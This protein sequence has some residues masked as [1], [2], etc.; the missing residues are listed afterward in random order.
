MPFPHVEHPKWLQTVP[1]RAIGHRHTARSI[2]AS[3]RRIR[4]GA[5]TLPTDGRGTAVVNGGGFAGMLAALALHA[6]ADRV[7]V[8]ER[9]RFPDTPG[10][11]PGQPQGHHAHLLLEAGHR[12]LEEQL[13]PGIRAQLLAAGASRV[14][15]SRELRWRSSAGWMAEHDSHLEILSCSRGLLD[16][17]LR[18]RV[19]AECPG[20]EVHEGTDVVGLLGSPE[21]VTGVRIRARGDHN[22]VH[23]VPAEM[24]VD[25]SGR[26]SSLPKWLTTL[27]CAPVRDERVDAG[28][29]YLSRQYHRPAGA[30]DLGFSALYLQT[31]PP[32]HPW[33][34]ALLPIEGN[35][36]IVS[37]GAM[38]GWEPAP[39][40]PG[41]NA[42]LAQLD[43]L[44]SE[45]LRDAEPASTVR[46]FHPGPSV[47]RHYEDKTTPDG[48]VALGDANSC[49][50]PVYGQGLSATAL[51][52]RELRDAVQHHGSLDHRATRAA[53][54]RIA[55]VT[56]P[57]WL[58]SASEDVRW[59]RTIGGPSGALTRIQHRFLDRV[60]ER[61]TTDPR[62]TAAFHEVM[63]LVSAP[64][65]LLR[66]TTLVPVLLGGR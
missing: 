6:V 31:R 48:L 49:F 58:M 1:A 19:L 23:D 54:T 57:A 35:R 9:D 42:V 53:R 27:G 11:R 20:I 65:T 47:R 38:Q 21:A 56:Q 33:T 41:F 50:N 60:L 16:H 59:P 13:L 36:W 32:D 4:S 43:P 17:M 55:A 18:S 52:A 30:A 22:D 46:G 10:T 62:V 7:V 44:L 12:V 40:D 3:S 61:S 66:P 24:V 51:S 29:R 26:H 25:A 8:I 37:L 15:M 63:S 45:I 28:V 34:G 39:G 5:T 64:T 14:A 2:S